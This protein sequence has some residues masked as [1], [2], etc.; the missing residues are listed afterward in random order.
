MLDKEEFLKLS[1]GEQVSALRLL[2]HF[3][4]VRIW[5]DDP[6]W[7][8]QGYYQNAAELDYSLYDFPPNIPKA[9]GHWAMTKTDSSVVP[10]FSLSKHVIE[11][12]TIIPFLAPEIAKMI[13]EKYE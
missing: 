10:Y 12:L 8:Y 13:R 2:I 3:A 5:A 11:T 7:L 1:K 9:Q 4:D 6:S